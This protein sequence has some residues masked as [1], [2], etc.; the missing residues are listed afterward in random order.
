MTLACLEALAAAAQ[1]AGLAADAVLVDDASTDGTADAVRRL[2]PWVEVVA[3]SGNL[4]WNRGMH[5]AFGR[6]MQRNADYYLWINDDTHLVPDA[7]ERML[8]QSAELAGREHRPVILVGAT[9]HPGS[10]H[11]SYGGRVR[12]GRWRPFRYRLVFDERQ[13]TPCHAI[14]G[15][16]VLIP[17]EVALRVGNLDPLFEHAMGDTDYGLRAAALDV[18]SFVAAGIVGHCSPNSLGG[19]YFDT[20]LPLARRWKLIR[21]RKGLPVRS[22][23][24]F[25]RRHGGIAWPL[26]FAWPYAK[27]IATG[28]TA[29]L[30]GRRAPAAASIGP[31]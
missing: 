31:R 18:P 1:R 21:S 25:C 12:E 16:C 15:N 27:V 30:T 2:H 4:F 3:G 28:L 5:M 14:E 9:A 29:A 13:P 23:L 10:T 6:A 20:S 7:L 8:R 22:W 26:H 11:V 19:T 24:H 17:R